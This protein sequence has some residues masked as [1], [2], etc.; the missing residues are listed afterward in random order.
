MLKT[1]EAPG[2]AITT[3]PACSSHT[4]HTIAHPGHEDQWYD[5]HTPAWCGLYCFACGRWLATYEQGQD[6]WTKRPV[7]LSDGRVLTDW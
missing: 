7:A 6:V 4:L 5:E 3:C 1:S 2:L